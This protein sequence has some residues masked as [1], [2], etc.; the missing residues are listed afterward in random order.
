MARR[1]EGLEA[2]AQRRAEAWRA[3]ELAQQQELRAAEEAQHALRADVAA[4]DALALQARRGWASAVDAGEALLASRSWRCTAP[5]RWVSG[6]LGHAAGSSPIIRMASILQ[7]TMHTT[8]YEWALVDGLFT[9][10][11][12]AALAGTFPA[13]GFATVAGDDGGKEYRYEARSLL[14]M[15][16]GS[17]SHAAALSEPWQRLAA[18]LA[19][20]GYRRAMSLLTGR[21]LSDCP[22]EANIFHYGPGASLGVHQDLADK[23]VTHVLYFNTAWDP[24][25]GGCLTIHTTKDGTEVAATIPPIVGTSA[26]LVRSDHSWHAVAKVKGDSPTSRRSVTV[27]FYRPGSI[28]TMWPPEASPTPSRG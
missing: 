2:E 15:G 26:V 25:R 1:I 5:L 10:S 11:D 19:S 7:S 28:S 24:A 9:S 14:A 22:I 4:R 16:S 17:P 6:R 18:D 23:V 13:N 12:A 27:T 20:P 8:P 21:D 3:V